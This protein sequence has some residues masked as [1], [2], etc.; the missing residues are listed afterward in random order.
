M[1]N[2]LT[3]ILIFISFSCQLNGQSLT[4]QNLI[5]DLS[6]FNEAILNGHPINY[7]RNQT[8]D[9]H[10]VIDLLCLLY[11]SDAADE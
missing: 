11:T 5:A 9:L 7:D 2:Q 10:Q 4:R 8:T 6:Y 3:L 1:T